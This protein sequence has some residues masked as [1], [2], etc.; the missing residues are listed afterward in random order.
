MT[1][2]HP[3]MVLETGRAA[4]AARIV[5]KEK[6]E[7]AAMLRNM[8]LF[9]AAPFV[10]LVYAVLLPFIG[11]GMLIVYGARA[12]YAT[13]KAHA[14]LRIGKKRVV[15]AVTPLAGLAYMVALPF[16]GMGMLIWVGARAFMAP[17]AA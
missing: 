17:A 8:A 4:I 10:G 6:V 7:P 9:L 16:I 12:F 11:L 2:L 5:R 3:A 13:G 1:T 15:C 14:A